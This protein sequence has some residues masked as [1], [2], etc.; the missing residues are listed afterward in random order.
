VTVAPVRVA[1]I[2]A[3]GLG[4]RFLP[5][6]KTVP[7]EML[8]LVDRPI[9]DVVVS[10]VVAAG[11][12][13][14]VIV[15]APGK[16]ALD[17]YFQPNP[18]LEARLAAEG[19]QRDLD[20]ARRGER[21][22]RRVTLVHQA[23]PRGNGDAVLRAREAVGRRPF[24]MI[25]GDDIVM[26]EPP[27]AAQLI[28]ARERL[29]GGSVAAAMRVAGAAIS[30][31]GA[32][33][34][35]QLDERSWRV[36]RLIEKPRPEEAPAGLAQV[37]GYVFEPEIFDELARTRAGKGGEIW[38]ADAVNALAQRAPVYAYEFAGERFD[39]GD[40]GEYVRAVVAAALERPELAH[41]LAEWMSVRIQ[42][43]RQRA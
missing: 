35:E 19:R 32:V 10:E 27:V 22:A 4:T 31:Y 1:V 17:A 24:V 43:K 13:E 20:L 2:P 34:G 18:R 36:R 26:S 25:W 21:I 8:P 39:T 37:H 16:A 7:K 42:D 41:D 33:E 29:G 23:E 15:S 11:V 30:R 38:L 3:A 40:R 5:V 9:V 12:D 28:H 6:T 14:V